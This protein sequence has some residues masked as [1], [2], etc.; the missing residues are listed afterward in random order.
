MADWNGEERRSV[1]IATLDEK[2]RGKLDVMH[3][4]VLELK[5]LITHPELGIIAKHGRMSKTIY[6]NGLPGL[7]MQTAMIWIA[8]GLLGCDNSFVRKLINMWWK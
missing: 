6:G 7:K 4:T 2:Q 1:I 5:T 3:D 8:V